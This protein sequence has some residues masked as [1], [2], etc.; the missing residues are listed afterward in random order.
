LNVNDLIS[1]YSDSKPAT[2]AS[3]RQEN[4]P[5]APNVS[6]SQRTAKQP[7]L[8][9]KSQ[10]PSLG[11]STKVTTPVKNGN[12]LG[13]NSNGKAFGGRH[14][15]NGSVSETSEG[16]ILEDAPTR[17]MQ[18][19]K[20]K[21]T[22]PDLTKIKGDE[23]PFRNPRDDQAT[24]PLY[25]RD[26]RDDSPPRR[27]PPT[28]PKAQAQ[29]IRDERRESFD[30]RSDQRSQP[31]YKS[32]RKQYPEP[33][34]RTY[35][36]RNSRDEEYRRTEPIA[37]SPREEFNRPVKEREQNPPTLNDILPIDDDLR[38][39]LDITGYH[40]APYRNKILNRRRA[41]AALD[42]QRDKLLAEMEAEERGGLPV[43]IRNQTPASSMLPPPIPNKLGGRIEPPLTSA[44]NSTVDTQHDRVISNKRPYSDVQDPR[45]EPI[46]GKFAR[47]DDRPSSQR[48]KEEDEVGFRRPR[49]KE[50]E[51]EYRRPHSSGFDGARRPSIDLRD[52]RYEVRGRSRERES[53]PGRRTYENRPA[54]RSRPYDDD[55][56]YRDE[57]PYEIH[58]S[59]KGKAYDP[60]YRGRGRGRARDNPYDR[61]PQDSDS[62]NEPGFGSRIANGR[63]YKDPRSF[64]RGGKGGP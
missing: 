46:G 63:P 32:E 48:A 58:G 36:R 30:P 64:D 14:H 62:K 57:R 55:L 38:E 16:E 34:K 54:T 4:L 59:Y 60:S 52:N 5:S 39:W 35:L 43:V 13:H 41:I 49:I 9:A 3:A 21:E 2:N 11:S 24:K 1:Q 15:S 19:P 40:N 6:T 8:T 12:Q 37:E 53:S 61:H 33:E 50:E 22:Q 27:P 28:N 31:E 10:V 47:V 17:L 51:E 45:D 18:P 42:A 7:D 23:H 20:P 44:G 25:S 26:S 29:R 56:P